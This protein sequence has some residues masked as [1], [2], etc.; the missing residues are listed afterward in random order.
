MKRKIS[1]LLAVVGALT[2]FASCSNR[3]PQQSEQGSYEIDYSQFDA[4]TEATLKI[5]IQS[6]DNEEALIRSVAEVFQEKYPKVEIK[7]DRMSGELSSTLMSYYNAEA[8]APG[9]MPDI[10]F[11]TSF[12]MLALSKKNIMLNMDPYLEAAS[13]QNLF[14]VN[15]YVPEYWTLGKKNFTNEQLMVPRSAD[16][17]VVHSNID[18]IKKAQAWCTGQHKTDADFLAGE[19]G[20]SQWITDGYIE[21]A[22]A[23]VDIMGRLK[24]GWTWEDYLYV[25]YW[26][27]QYYD[28]IGWTAAK[29]YYLVDAYLNWEANYNPIFEAM[30]VKYFN[31]DGS[32]NTDTENWQRALDMIKFLIAQGFSAPFKGGSAGFTGGKGVFLIHSQAMAITL[33]K[34]QALDAYKNVTDMSEVFD[35]YTFPLIEYNDTPKIGA[36]IA[37]YSVYK[38]SRNRELAMLFLLEIISAR[39]QTAMADVGINYPSIRVDMQNTKAPWAEKYSAYN[40]EAYIW[41]Q[42]YTCATDYFL[43]HEPEYASDIMEAVQTMISSYADG[44]KGLSTVLNNCKDDIEYYLSF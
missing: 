24:N 17:V 39:G 40:M 21:D 29:G 16:R 44:T 5:S 10:W 38:N 30:G 12:N 41:G 23:A 18:I 19:V 20:Q 32:F 37:G 1:L 33:S 6:Y 28:S 25:L 34:L 27:R 35:I 4:E 36:G 31:D 26:C 11:S 3:V 15:E 13:S 9:T 43:A 42:E 14:D 8:N 7:I 2:F 22:S